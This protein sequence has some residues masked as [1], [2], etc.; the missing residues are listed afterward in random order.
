ML[1]SVREEE[2][3]GKQLQ[4]V[5]WEGGLSISRAQGDSAVARKLPSAKLL[6]TT[7]RDHKPDTGSVAAVADAVRRGADLRLFYTFQFEGTG[8]VEETMTLQTT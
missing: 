8:L 3:S 5:F 4:R 2:N 1:D 7:N 6:C